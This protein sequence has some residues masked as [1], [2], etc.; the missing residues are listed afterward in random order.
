M[1]RGDKQESIVYFLLGKQVYTTVSEI[2]N[3]L[4]VSSKT[5]YR[6]IKK[7]ND[8][9]ENG[10][11]IK[12]EK[13]KGI[14]LNYDIYLENRN[15]SK[16][17]TVCNYSPVERRL[18][19]IKMLLFKS[20][21]YLKEDDL[22]RKYYLSS[23]VIRA[24]EEIIAEQLKSK[25]LTLKKYKDSLS[26]IGSEMDI[27]KALIDILL[28]S[29][30]LNF[31]DLKLIDI[32][33]SKNDLEFVSNEIEDIQKKLNIMIPYPYNINLFTHL[34]ILINRSKKGIFDLN[35]N[36]E[37]IYGKDVK[38]IDKE[39]Y[40]ISIKVKEN[41]E[42]YINKELPESEATNIYIYLISSRIENTE[43]VHVVFPLDVSNITNFFIDQFEKEY[44]L[45][46]V[47]E[48]IF[49]DLASHIKPMLNRLESNISIKNNLIEDI[50]LE[51]KGLFNIISKIAVET[52][53]KYSLSTI[54]EDEVGFIVLYFAKYIEQYPEK[55]KVVIL[56][57]T[58]I[59]TSELLKVKIMKFFPELDI[60]TTV[61]LKECTEDFLN[62][63]NADLV[64]TTVK[65]N[66]EFRIPTVL[67]NTLFTK[68]DQDKVRRIIKEIIWNRQGKAI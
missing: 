15:T 51:Y 28:K 10:E 30:I 27:R 45:T 54:T 52:S 4:D 60:E 64:L 20:P 46:I 50:K 35:N 34:Y 32:S 68:N 59:G 22:F 57:T 13:G 16:K 66:E 21:D 18:N 61:S 56:C 31:D 24:D 8:S 40:N 5:V 47:K 36:H 12:T 48:L 55:I 39:Y 65:T 33:F 11:L 6:L 42:K 58:G 19:I 53:K 25:K 67:V 17:E 7:I 9:C 14:K 37:N 38:G 2:A 1:N 29:D 49:N 23:S 26:I 62:N 43:K 63:I 41:I 44:N 3:Y